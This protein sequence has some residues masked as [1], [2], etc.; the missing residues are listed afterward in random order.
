MTPGA[1]IL[2][3]R[4]RDEVVGGALT[5]ACVG[6]AL[7]VVPGMASMAAAVEPISTDR[8]G[9]ATSTDIVEPGALQME[10]GVQYQPARDQRTPDLSL[11]QLV[12]RWAPLTWLELRLGEN[13]SVYT[14]RRT[15]AGTSTTSE[16]TLATKARFV[17]QR[18][19]VPTLGALLELDIPLGTSGVATNS[20]DPSLTFLAAWDLTT[21]WSLDANLGLSGPSQGIH[22]TTRVLQID[23]I[24]SL[25]WSAS[26]RLGLFVE[27]FS[28]VKVN[29][30]PTQRST[31]GGVTYLLSDNLQVDVAAGVG[32][33]AAAPD[34]YVGAGFA[35]RWWLP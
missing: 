8:P 16:I 7:V 17:E 28:S 26:E 12:L 10:L 11:P 13:T 24:L 35:W 20:V 29:D 31:D 2:M 27:W 18:D 21:D 30:E 5:W 23:P 6:R 32:L 19:A 3:R 33:N 25:E 4:G 1:V 22:D 9:Q 34:Y 15:G 14:Q